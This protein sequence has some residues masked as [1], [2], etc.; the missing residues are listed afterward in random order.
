LGLD[1]TG[2]TCCG[3]LWLLG[4]LAFRYYVVNFGSYQS[5]YGTITGVMLLLLW[6]YL[7]GLVVIVG[8][9][10]SAE[11]EHASEWGKAPGEKVPGEKKKLGSAAAREFKQR[12]S[13]PVP[14]APPA[15]DEAPNAYELPHPSFLDR[16]GTLAL[17]FMV[18][19]QRSKV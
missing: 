19:R 5:T 11:I 6:F 15:Q 14:G 3:G 18:W 2:V 16:L 12:G 17:L 13:Q 4:S 9:E 10:I 8:A 7:T 1:Y